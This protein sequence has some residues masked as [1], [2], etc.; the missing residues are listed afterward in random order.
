MGV[1]RALDADVG[2][3][4]E[5]EYRI[6]GSDGPGMFDIAANRSTQDGVIVLRKVGE[7]HV[8]PG[9]PQR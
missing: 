1:V 5:M 9:R 4:A 7:G 2:R 8:T 6:I 3:N